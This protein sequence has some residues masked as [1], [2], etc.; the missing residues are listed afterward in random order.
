MNTPSIPIHLTLLFSIGLSCA[1]SALAGANLEPILTVPDA[2]VFRNDFSKS[3]PLAKG[4]WSLRQHTRWTIEEGVLRGIPSTL[5]YQNSRKDHQGFEPRI[6]CP[7]TPAEFIAE[8]S[9]RFNG[10]AE[11]S[12]APFVEFGHH[13]A[14]VKFSESGISLI[15]DGESVKLDEDKGFKYES[16]KWYHALAELKGDEFVIQFADGPT[17]YGKHPRFA[18]PV[19]S[20]GAGFGVAGTRGGVVE[21]D[22]LTLSTIKNQ[23]N[24]GWKSTRKRFAPFEP[25]VLKEKKK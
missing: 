14:R 9:I 18:Q 10:G 21:I 13:I 20:G 23:P 6:S 15:A 1:T 17:L 22:H 7:A 3:E 16:G 4:S 11:T 12:I 25:I 8:F 2:I 24:P 19:S 5:E